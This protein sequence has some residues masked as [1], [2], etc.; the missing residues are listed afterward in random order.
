MSAEQ[1]VILTSKEGENFEVSKKA[2]LMCGLIKDMLEEAEEDEVSIIPVPN[3]SSTTLKLVIQYCNEHVDE[4]S[5]EIEKPL[6]GKI[7]DIL[8]E[9]DRKFLELVEQASAQTG[10]N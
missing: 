3:V 10:T 8:S 7:E 6:K 1:K 2:I 5:E 9:K 4:P